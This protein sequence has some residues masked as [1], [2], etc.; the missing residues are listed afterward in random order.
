MRQYS[1]STDLSMLETVSD[2]R[3]GRRVNGMMNLSRNINMSTP[4]N[5][6]L[7][8]LRRPLIFFFFLNAC[9]SVHSFT[10]H[11]AD[12]GSSARWTR[13]SASALMLLCRPSPSSARSGWESSSV[14]PLFSSARPISCR[15]CVC[16]FDLPLHRERHSRS[17]KKAPSSSRIAPMTPPTAAPAIPP[18]EIPCLPPSLLLL[19]GFG[20]TSTLLELLKLLELLEEIVREEE[21]FEEA[22]SIV[23][24]LWRLEG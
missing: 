21:G 11:F 24:A 13:E 7:T 10:H 1:E 23:S 3:V 18:V 9:R 6:H 2:A 17:R 15:Y 4:T 5:L 12:P 8:R 16:P 20:V 14:G 22:N 19:P